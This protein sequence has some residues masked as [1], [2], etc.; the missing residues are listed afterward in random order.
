[1]VKGAGTDANV[2][3]VLYGEHGRSGPWRLRESFKDLFERGK[4]DTFVL[5]AAFLGEL[6]AIKIGHDGRRPNSAWYLETVFVQDTLQGGEWEFECR[7]WL[8][9]KLSQDGKRVKQLPG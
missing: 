9:L 1:M 7:S 5:E 6:K 4:M 2:N 8:D 3:V